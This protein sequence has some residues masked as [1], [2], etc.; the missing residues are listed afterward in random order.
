MFAPVVPIHQ[1]AGGLAVL[2]RLIA[3]NPFP[4]LPK[5]DGS[6]GGVVL[7]VP[8]AEARKFIDGGET[9][10]NQLFRQR[11]FPLAPADTR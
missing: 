2:V 8:G 1:K 9:A 4:S 3:G 7:N 11:W 6:Q 10:L 5:Q